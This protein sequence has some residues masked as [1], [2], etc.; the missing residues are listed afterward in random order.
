MTDREAFADDILEEVDDFETEKMT[1]LQRLRGYWQVFTRGLKATKPYLIVL[2]LVVILVAIFFWKWIFIT[3]AA[4]EGGVLYRRFFGGTVVDYVYPEGFHII[5]PWDTMTIYNARVQIIK[6][7]FDVLTNRGLPLHLRIAVRFRPEYELIAVLHQQ[8]GPDYIDKVI[9]PQIESVLRRE[10]GKHDP[11]DIY[12]NKAGVLTN[13]ILLAIEETSKKY[14]RITDIIIRSLSLPPAVKEAIDQKLVN[15]QQF[16]AYEFL[17]QRER[18]EAERKRIEAQGIKDFQA[19]VA[20]TLDDQLLDWH[21]VEATRD[22][23]KSDN[24]KIVII[25]ASEKGLPLILGR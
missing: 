4:G 1:F 7:E 3:V 24:S 17:L 19:I 16:K 20:E 18:Q 6:H 23:A 9:I 15:E 10:I 8:V 11:E 21:G 2:I 22:I 5:P 14:V 25:G 13:I 12:T